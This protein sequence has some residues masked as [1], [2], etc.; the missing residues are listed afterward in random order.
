M[1]FGT[2]LALLACGTQ[3]F[4]SVSE[5]YF[6]PLLQI[7]VGFFLSLYFYLAGVEKQ[8]IYICCLLTAG[9]YRAAG[10]ISPSV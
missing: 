3:T 6:L 8:G 10:D 2:L 5:V 1:G 4:P 9:H 7:C